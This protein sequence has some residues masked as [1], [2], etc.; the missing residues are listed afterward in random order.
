MQKKCHACGVASFLFLP[1]PITQDEDISNMQVD[2]YDSSTFWLNTACR[3]FSL[4]HLRTT[5]FFSSPSSQLHSRASSSSIYSKWG[6]MGARPPA[7][8]RPQGTRWALAGEARQ[9]GARRRHD[10]QGTLRGGRR[11]ASRARRAGARHRACSAR[12]STMGVGGAR[13]PWVWPPRLRAR[14]GRDAQGLGHGGAV[15]TA[16]CIGKTWTGLHF[17]G[18]E[19]SAGRR[20]TVARRRGEHRE[21]HEGERRREHTW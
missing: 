17:H 1:T 5:V 8:R 19:G 18:K 16:R 15:S 7:G 9:S 2:P 14:K 4:M 3:S 12:A 6:L 10:S 13:R 21:E 20:R 11:S